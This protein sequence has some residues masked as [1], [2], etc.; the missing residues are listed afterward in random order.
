MKSTFNAWWKSLTTLAIFSFVQLI[1]FGQDSGNG[2]TSTSVKTTTTSHTEW[3]AAP[4]VW[5]VTGVVV[6]LLLVVL[7][8]GRRSSSS[9]TTI[10]DAGTTRTIATDTSEV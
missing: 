6:I 7:L 5:I 10:T 2:G 9:R 8:S 1:S 4:W 3:Y